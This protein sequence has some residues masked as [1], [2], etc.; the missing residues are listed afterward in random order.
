[1][2]EHLILELFLTILWLTPTAVIVF[3]LLLIVYIGGML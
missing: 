1:M 2:I 3:I